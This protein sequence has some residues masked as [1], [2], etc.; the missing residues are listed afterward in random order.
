M[1]K[2]ISLFLL[3]FLSLFILSSCT[4]AKKA[5]PRKTGEINVSAAISLKDVLEEMKK[6]YENKH[7]DV[8]LVLN[9][10]SSGSLQKQVEQGAPTDLLISA[11]KEQMDALEKKSLIQKN[12]RVAKFRSCR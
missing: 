8:K 3:L 11:A 2:R 10:G 5:V 6:N 7:S 9:F 4:P 12:T 1:K